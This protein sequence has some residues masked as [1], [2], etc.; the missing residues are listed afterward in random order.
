MGRGTVE[1]I[2]LPFAQVSLFWKKPVTPFR[3]N[4]L[5]SFSVVNSIVGTKRLTTYQI[6]KGNSDVLNVKDICYTVYWLVAI[7]CHLCCMYD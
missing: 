6:S 3:K 5:R 7:H 1:N 4:I 2:K